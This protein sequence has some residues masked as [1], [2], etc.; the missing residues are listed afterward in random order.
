[1]PVRSTHAGP[2]DRDPRGLGPKKRYQKRYQ[3]SYQKRYH[4]GY[5]KRYENPEKGRYKSRV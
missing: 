3:N 5:Q 2:K 4:K 1:M